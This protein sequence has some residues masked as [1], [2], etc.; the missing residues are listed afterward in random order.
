MD[1]P[2]QWSADTVSTN[3]IDI[4]YYRVGSGQPIVMAHGMYDSGQRWIPLGEELTDDYEVIT[5][6]ARG[7]GHTDAPET[8]YDLDSRVADLL[9]LIE[10]LDISDPIL[11]G[12]S[13]GAATV[14][15]AGATT[16]ELPR[17]I[18]LAD[19]SRFHDNPDIDPDE[20]A[21]LTRK[22]LE[23]SQSRPIE[24][25]VTEQVEEAEVSSEHARRLVASTDQC[26]PHIGQ[27]GQEH[28]PVAEAFDDITCPTLVLR[29][30]ADVSDRV[31]DLRAAKRLATGR[32]VHLSGAG[33]YVF[34]DEYEAAY[35]ELQTFLQRL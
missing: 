26:S 25:R 16:P 4:Q 15:W 34:R 13:M 8:G 22:K 18:V 35:T 2:E 27:I 9:G 5:Y 30:D 32:L 10:A 3:G 23:E 17:G 14:A 1:I 12:H 31:T 24:E 6:D 7:H 19:P 20:I 11:L 28:T 21:A 29:H 33:H